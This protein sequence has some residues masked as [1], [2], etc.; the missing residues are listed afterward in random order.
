MKTIL[1]ALNSSYVHT[2]LAVR[3][4]KNSLEESGIESTII[5]RS[6][7]DKRLAV[8]NEL[9][10]QNADIYCFSA[11]IWNITEMLFFARQLHTLLPNSVIIFGGPEVSFEEESFFDQHPYIDCIISGEG[12]RSLP[13]LIQSIKDKANNIDDIKHKIIHSEVYED[14]IHQGVLYN[15]EEAFN[16]NILYYESSRGCPFNCTY[17]LS[18]STKGVRG[19]PASAVLSD[20]RSFES[21]NGVRII[22]FIDRTFNYNKKRTIDILTGLL[23]DE[24]TKKYHFEICA[25]LLDE[26]TIELF[27]KF[28]K[29]KLQLEIGIQSTNPETLK[30]IN[31]VNNTEK[32]LSAL[33]KL[34][35]KGNI[36]L[37]ADL[38]AGLPFEDYSSFA[39]SF[40][41]LYGKCDVLQLGFLKLLKGS[42]LREN[43]SKYGI[44]YSDDP[45]YE[46]FKTNWLSFSDI[47]RL[48][49]IDE[50]V[51]RFSNSGHFSH[52]L[53]E[54]SKRNVS[55]F[56]FF[57]G[58]SKAAEERFGTLQY[59]Q[60]N[61][62]SLITSY[63][64]STLSLLENEKQR[65][66]A[67][68][69]LDFLIN[70]NGSVPPFLRG[71][72]ENPVIPI[73]RSELIRRSGFEPAVSEVH[74]FCFD[75]DTYYVI[76]RKNHNC[77][78]ICLD[79]SG[80]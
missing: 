39:R 40:D 68:A 42:S 62:Y 45:P 3:C 60:I 59:S 73:I 16:M 8:L 30:A 10:T 36:K 41:D 14:F 28:P 65:L 33:S 7:K 74:R 12:E 58:L 43:A 75:Q 34:R 4:L 18:S 21:I 76:D 57:E 17:C 9:Y 31:R 63:A 37:H 67:S 54:I 15:A 1:F 29:D 77:I 44:L 53:D 26:E 52:L 20:L 47:I 71:D 61:A 70:E 24:Y 25:D 78:K 38:I 51:D 19:K 35:Q 23:S 13:K 48:H 80:L 32:C 6:L 66:I 49:K 55:P 11:Y 5:E 79:S 72:I 46:V 27:G 22:K 56:E 2:N 64:I 50:I 69:R